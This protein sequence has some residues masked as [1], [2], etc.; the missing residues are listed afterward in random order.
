MNSIT[1]NDSNCHVVPLWVLA[2]EVT[3]R[4]GGANPDKVDPSHGGTRARILVVGEEWEASTKP[5]EGGYLWDQDA[6]A[7]GEYVMVEAMAIADLTFADI[8]FV[9]AYPCPVENKTPH[10][11]MIAVQ[12]IASVLQAMPEASTVVALGKGTAGLVRTA[13]DRHAQH[14]PTR[15]IETFT[16]GPRSAGR[17][18]GREA[19]AIAIGAALTEA[20]LREFPLGID[21][22]G[23]D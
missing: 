20:R 1:M 15:V 16:Y 23:D 17:A 9:N 6:Q 5:T 18:G 4:L 11:R 2:A 14:N 21:R 12:H 3:R 7:H 10:A 19:Q 22:D 13:L 8:A